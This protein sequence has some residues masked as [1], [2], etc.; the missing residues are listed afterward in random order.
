MKLSCV[1]V[2]CNENTKYLDFW[3]AV[4]EAWW[5]VAHLPCIMVYVGNE[6]PNHLRND[7]AVRFFKAIPGWPTSTQAQCIR[8]LYPALLQTQDAVMISDMDMI[9]LQRHFFT[10]G[11]QPFNNNQFV[12]LRGIDEREKQIYMCYV[13]ATP[14]VWSEL[15]QITSEDDIRNRLIDWSQVSPS[16]GRHGGIGWCSDQLVLYNKVK[17]WQQVWPDRVGLKPWTQEIPRLCR[18]NPYEW[19]VWSNELEHKIKNAQ[20]VDFHMPSFQNYSSIIFKVLEAAWSP[21]YS[22]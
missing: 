12:S 9:P 18:S 5:K 2:A 4:K 6:L 3:P 17:A 7:P 21:Q 20:Y 10:E 15:F 22:E 16:D 8:L 13:G 14:R 1:L 11:F 19:A